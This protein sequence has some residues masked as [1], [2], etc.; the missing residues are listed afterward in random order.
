MNGVSGIARLAMKKYYRKIQMP[1]HGEV[2][3][4]CQRNYVLRDLSD[5]KNKMNLDTRLAPFNN[6][7]DS[8][9]STSRKTIAHSTE[10]IKNYGIAIMNINLTAT[11]PTITKSTTLDPTNETY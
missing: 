6:Q 10:V 11:S 4:N 1:S 3:G 7:E 2:G 5:L 9:H 8:G